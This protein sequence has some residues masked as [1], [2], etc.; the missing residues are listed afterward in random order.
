MKDS[1]GYCFGG[2]GCGVV[3]DGECFLGDDTQ[4]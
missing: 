2:G 3:V 4:G 1:W